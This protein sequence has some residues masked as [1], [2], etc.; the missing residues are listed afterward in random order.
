MGYREIVSEAKRLPLNE[1]LRLVEELLRGMRAA[2]SGSP[3]QK[4]RQIK[5]FSE[6]RGFLRPEGP[7]P[8][9][10]ELDEEYTQHL[11]EKYL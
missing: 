4:G 10:S 2:E 9:D 5:P 1:Q 11:I 3:S 7:A 8:T 6:M